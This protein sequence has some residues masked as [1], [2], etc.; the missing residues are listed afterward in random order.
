MHRRRAD[1]AGRAALTTSLM[2]RKPLRG[3]VAKASLVN[4]LALSILVLLGVAR[5]SQARSEQIWLAP[6]DTMTKTSSDFPD[7]FAKPESWQSAAKLTRVVSLP[8][9]YILHAPMQLIKQ[10]LR[11]LSGMDIKL[12]VSIL[13]LPVDKHVCGTNVEGTVWPGEPKAFAKGLASL[14][15]DVAIFSFDGPLTSGHI[16]QGQSACRFSINETAQRVAQTVRTLR[17]V[18]PHALF[19][20]SEPPNWLSESEWKQTLVHWLRAY[21]AATGE[22]LYGL[23]MDVN[24]NHPW[25]RAVGDSISILHGQGVLAGIFFNAGTAPNA[26]PQLWI[27]EAKK[28]VCNVVLAHFDLDYVVFSNWS[29]MN[30]RNLPS[31]NEM[32]LTS[33]VERYGNGSLCLGFRRR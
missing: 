32:T 13:A 28:N 23:T 20:N 22:S 9:E 2:I 24:W 19:V 16:Y 26:R 29:D 14:G 31:S 25:V 33:L 1:R 21:K 15:V 6:P 11:A 3:K 30:V 4:H 27:A 8:I 7:L 10:Q 17:D 5:S 18:Y 12:D